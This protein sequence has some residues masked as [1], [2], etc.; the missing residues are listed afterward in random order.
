MKIEGL[1]KIIWSVLAVAIS[2]LV[3]AIV[4][5][6]MLRRSRRTLVG[7]F[8]GSLGDTYISLIRSAVRYLFII[9]TLVVV[10]SIN[11]VN[12]GGL[13]A[14]LGIFGV[15]IGLAVQDALKDVI[16]GVSLVSDKYF[17]VGDLVEIGDYTGV[18]KSLGIKTT[19]ILAAG[20]MVSI[21]NRN[22]EN[23][24]VVQGRIFLNVG[25][26]YELKLVEADKVMKEIV[27]EVEKI[28][29]VEL[30]EYQG[31]KNLGESK[32]EYGLKVE[33]KQPLKRAETERK[34]WR[35]VLETTE[36]HQIAIPYPQIDIHNKK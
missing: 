26:P 23:V 6:V 24:K 3:Y 2:M 7:K 19:K 10:L 28:A 5:A 25:L 12:V 14:G 22:I 29:D 36:K 17:R 11:G 8:F 30:C 4:D 13:M 9:V 16:R 18:V 27:S 31:V 33:V 20:N 34:I 32:I 21:A 15:V 1:E 35:I